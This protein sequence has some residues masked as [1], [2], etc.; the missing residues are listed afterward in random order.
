MILMYWEF[1]T[2][3]YKKSSLSEY[4]KANYNRHSIWK[5][6]YWDVFFPYNV[7]MILILNY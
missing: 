1:D 2:V 4:S 7:H 3:Y 6:I 5:V